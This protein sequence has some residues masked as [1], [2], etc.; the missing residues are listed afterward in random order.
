MCKFDTLIAILVSVCLNTPA[1]KITQVSSQA[2]CHLSSFFVL[3]CSPQICNL[4][5]QLEQFKEELE[6]KSEEVQQ[7]HMQLEIQRKEISSQ[8]E[9]LETREGLIKVNRRLTVSV[10]QY[11]IQRKDWSR[12]RFNLAVCLC[13]LVPVGIFTPQTLNIQP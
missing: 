3:V 8:Q 10:L 6:N 11:H 12:N 9:Y 1:E 7:L 5:E 2:F 4:E 13:S